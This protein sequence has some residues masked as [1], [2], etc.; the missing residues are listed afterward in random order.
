MRVAEI[1]D[2]AIRNAINNIHLLKN[3]KN[4]IFRCANERNLDWLTKKESMSKR[5]GIKNIN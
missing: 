1:L 4:Y 2:R 3:N 5:N